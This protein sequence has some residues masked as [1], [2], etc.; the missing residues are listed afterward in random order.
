[1]TLFQGLSGEF[2]M[3]NKFDIT[4]HKWDDNNVSIVTCACGLMDIGM[5][6]FH[7]TQEPI[8]TLNKND[9]IAIAKHFNLLPLASNVSITTEVGQLVSITNDKGESIPFEWRENI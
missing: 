5:Y 9:A 1:M 3:P 8:L 2:L 7:T 4:K 6:G